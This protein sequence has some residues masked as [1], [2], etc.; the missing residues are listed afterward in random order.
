M[1]V[2]LSHLQYV[3]ATSSTQAFINSVSIKFLYT[4]FERFNALGGVSLLR[5]H[6]YM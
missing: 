4:W 1:F 6:L 2:S 5:I 3:R